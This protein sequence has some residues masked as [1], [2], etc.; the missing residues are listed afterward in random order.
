MEPILSIAVPAYGH[1]KKL[2]ENIAHWLTYEREDI[3]ILIVDNDATGKEIKEHMLAIKDNR[4]HYYQNE[5]NI[6]RCNN[7]VRAIELASSNNVLVC[8]AEREICLDM[9]DDLMGYIV[10]YP[11]YGIITG[12]ILDQD[13]NNVYT[14]VPGIYKRG[15]EALMHIKFMGDLIP[16]LV[17]R[18][19]L[20][21]ETLYAA[22]EHYMQYRI[23]LTAIINGD[24]IH[25]DKQ[26]GSMLSDIYLTLN[27]DHENTPCL[28]EGKKVEEWVL[29]DMFTPRAR[30]MEVRQYIELTD[31]C[32]FR[33]NQRISLINKWIANFMGKALVY[34]LECQCPYD[35]RIL[36]EVPLIGYQEVFEEWKC[37]LL[38]FFQQKEKEGKYCYVGHLEDMIKN[39]LILL[40]QAEEIL[41]DIQKSRKI[42]I[43]GQGELFE[44]LQIILSY[45]KYDS[46]LF[47]NSL[48]IESSLVL[49][50]FMYDKDIEE[51]LLKQGAQKVIFMDRMA[52]YLSIV[53]CSKHLTPDNFNYW[54]VYIDY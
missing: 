25:L 38:S 36:G 41:D 32:E 19:H 24:F 40:H 3:E 45:M 11:D 54:T 21:F 51:K 20:C 50:P 13:G 31:H 23:A 4:F 53:W 9:L 44:H 14:C 29:T 37:E 1:S 52:K 2:K 18:R 7:I 22:N 34:V 6:G 49:L 47:E 8:A 35:R 26:L 28:A 42:V 16:M 43:Y 33:L 12:V 17:N 27:S 15:M 39:E 48:S 30:A 5:K 10:K 46:F